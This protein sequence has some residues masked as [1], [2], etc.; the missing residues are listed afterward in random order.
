MYLPYYSIKRNKK[1]MKVL[2][3]SR[4][5]GSAKH[6]INQYAVRS[7]VLDQA[8]AIE[9]QGINITH[10]LIKSGGIRGYVKGVISLRREIKKNTYDILHAHFGLTAIVC[11]FQFKLPFVITFH[12][13]DIN[14]P[15]LSFISKFV[16]LFAKQ[17]I[18][19]SKYL[20]SK[21]NSKNISVIPCGV[22]LD[23]FYPIEKATKNLKA[24]KEDYYNVLFSGQAFRELKNYPLA[25]L[26]VEKTKLDK[27]I[28]LIELKGFSREEMNILLNQV[29][30]V[31]MTSLTEGS[32]QVIKEAM[33]SN[34]P[35][36]TTDVG[37]VKDLLKNVKPC[38]ITSFDSNEISEALQKTLLTNKRANYRNYIKRLD[39]KIIAQDVIDVYQEVLKN[40]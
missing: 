21:V 22:D 6:K 9:K 24:I 19:V 25:K 3:V 17:N 20:K 2:I 8:N 30:C 35:I 5:A 32:P 13:S 36:V 28:N 16:M 29:D 39:N 11:L 10:F 38:Y 15:K 33:A 27:P 18:V 31:L 14:N 26:V 37:D 7:Y 4:R 1:I 12:G 34:C 40:K 23:V